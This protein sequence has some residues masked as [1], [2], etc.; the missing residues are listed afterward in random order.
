MAR[1]EACCLYARKLR[2]IATPLEMGMLVDRK[3]APKWVVL[4]RLLAEAEE[5]P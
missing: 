4:F 2:V 1:L 5:A 3:L